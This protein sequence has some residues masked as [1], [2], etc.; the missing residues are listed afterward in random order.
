[1]GGDIINMTQYPEVVLASEQGMCYLN[2]S[3]VTDYDVGIYAKG[4]TKPVSIEEVLAN[5]K[6]N[7]E[8]LKNLVSG[9]IKNMPEEKG[10]ECKEKAERALM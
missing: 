3:L 5:F 4:K 9:I 10:C 7:T 2:I 1:M 6:K 8:K